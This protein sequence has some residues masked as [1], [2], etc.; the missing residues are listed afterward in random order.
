MNLKQRT[1]THWRGEAQPDPTT[2]LKL[3]THTVC[4]CVG[5]C[6]FFLQRQKGQSS[7]TQHTTHLP[8]HT[9]PLSGPGRS[10]RGT[11]STLFVSG[12]AC[13]C[14]CGFHCGTLLR[15]PSLGPSFVP[16]PFEEAYLV[17]CVCTCAC[18]SCVVF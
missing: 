7:V 1:H 9:N 10:R 14:V 12:G 18:G 16:F 8:T 5:A 13:A 2:T 3:M 6:G 17:G 4:E 15:G 11:K